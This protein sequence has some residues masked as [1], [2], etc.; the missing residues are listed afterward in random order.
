VKPKSAADLL[1]LK[2]N[3]F[4]ESREDAVTGGTLTSYEEYKYLTG[5]IQ[6]LR[7]AKNEIEQLKRKY[8]RDDED[9]D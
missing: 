2:L 1:L 4:I 3:E 6:G 8:E 5:V 7:M 9:L